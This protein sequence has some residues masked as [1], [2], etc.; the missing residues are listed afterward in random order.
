MRVNYHGYFLIEAQTGRRI[1]FD[2]RPFLSAFCRYATAEH[3]NSFRYTDEHAYLF[4]QVG[5]LYVFVVTRSKEIIKRVNTTS[6]GIEDIQSILAQGEHLG[7]ASYMML[8]QHVF[9]FGSTV[10]APRF[11]AFTE[12]VDE[13]LRSVGLGHYQM[14]VE[15]LL[16]QA[17]KSDVLKMGFVGQTSMQVSTDNS[18]GRQ[19]LNVFNV[20]DA[21]ADLIDSF[22]IVIRP[23]KRENIK[24]AVRSVLDAVPDDGLNRMLVKAKME[25]RGHL[26]DLYLAGRGQIADVI[27]TKDEGKIQQQLEAKM[28]E[29]VT[30]HQKVQEFEQNDAYEKAD[31][32]DVSRY[33]AA[34]PWAGV[35]GAI[36]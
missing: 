23:K 12:F 18:I 6:I 11:N 28:Q 25:A 20:P 22:D 2:L 1:L 7:F 36:R 29:N 33:S 3:K 35:V 14:G 16:Y 32:D 34:A 8:K 9:A 10:L 15:P 13:L 4:H 24:P 31:L 21:N 17:T 5:D 19:L 30:L 26:A 27:R